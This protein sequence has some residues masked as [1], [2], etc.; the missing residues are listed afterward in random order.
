MNTFKNAK[1]PILGTGTI[2]YTV[3]PAT[4]T[5]VHSIYIANITPINAHVTIKVGAIRLAF[6]KQVLAEDYITLDKPINLITGEA[7]TIVAEDGDN[8]I[9]AFV[10]VMEIT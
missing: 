8:T 4:Q 1:Q 9:E 10:S 6:N 7:I 5:V 3:P 2:I